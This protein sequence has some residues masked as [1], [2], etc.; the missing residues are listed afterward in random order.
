MNPK[1]KKIEMNVN[2]VFKYFNQKH[3]DVGINKKKKTKLLI[4]YY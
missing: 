1:T 3:L 4:I 2:C